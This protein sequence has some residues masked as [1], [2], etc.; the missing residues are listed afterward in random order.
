MVKDASR[1]QAHQGKVCLQPL[2][3]IKLN[4]SGYYEPKKC[5]G[6]ILQGWFVELRQGLSYQRREEN[7]ASQ[8]QR[9]LGNELPILLV[10][11]LGDP[12]GLLTAGCMGVGGPGP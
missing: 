12:V 9:A 1:L 4:N 11:L 2:S 6:V 10:N 7:I 8:V 3:I 5:S